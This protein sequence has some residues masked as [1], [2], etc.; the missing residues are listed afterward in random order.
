MAYSIRKNQLNQTRE[1]RERTWPDSF[2]KVRGG[3]YVVQVACCQSRRMRCTV[4]M[5]M[6]VWYAIS[7]VLR[8]NER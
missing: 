5:L 8:V 3:L 6:P 1:A 2:G 4:R 7:W